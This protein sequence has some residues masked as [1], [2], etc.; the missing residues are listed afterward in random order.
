MIFRTRFEECMAMLKGIAHFERSHVFWSGYHDDQAVAETEVHWIR[1]REWHG[2][3]SRHTTQE[4]V[5]VCREMGIP[6]IDM[7]DVDVFPGVPKIRPDNRRIGQIGA[8]H[9]RDRGYRNV[10]F[11]GFSNLGWSRERRDGFA[12]SALAA[13]QDCS[14]F[15]VDFPGSSTP[16]WD[17][18]QIE[19]IAVWLR[20]LSKPFAVMACNDMRAQ[21]I[22][23]AARAAEILVPEQ[24]AVLGANNDIVRCEMTI[25]AISS[26]APNAFQSGFRAAGMLNEILSGRDVV[27]MDQRVEP[28]GVVVRHSTDTLA[29][30]DEKIA[31]AVNFIRKSACTG[32]TADQ[33]ADSAHISR[34]LLEKKFRH[35]IGRSPQAEIRRVQV[36]RIGQLLVATDFPLKK[37]AEMTGFEYTEYMCVL[38][39]RTTGYTPGAYRDTMKDKANVRSSGP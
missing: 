9:F 25:P 37:I 5:D 6:L 11:A 31:A 13:G 27:S 34:S 8:E 20:A 21:Q 28:L 10:G 16:F 2:V 29:I 14:L 35:Y 39:K 15:E 17:D 12:E 1:K 24:L 36:D 18:E 7:N 19:E 4:L 3:I 22:I 30:D 38:F 32:V 23:S 33:V 26:V